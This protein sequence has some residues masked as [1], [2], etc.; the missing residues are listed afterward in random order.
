MLFNKF[1]SSVLLAVLY[2]STALSAPWPQSSKH[3][4][5]RTREIASGFT[6]ET[7][8]PA[9]K[10]E[11]F[12]EGIDHPLSKRAEFTVA[13]SA[14][15]FAASH[16]GIPESAIAYKSGFTGEVA[17]HAYLRQTH[18]GIMFANAVANVAFNKANKV[19]VVLNTLYHR[20][21][22]HVILGRLFWFFVCEAQ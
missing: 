15:S 11:T 2:A 6:L 17:S 12:G 5:H 21:T 1:F 18:D 4:T 20:M 19:S 13:D 9:S 16:L 8:H 22:G 3:I 10:Y 7:F 14:K